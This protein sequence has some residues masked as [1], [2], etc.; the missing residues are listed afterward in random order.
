MKLN[1]VDDTDGFVLHE[2]ENAFSAEIDI[3]TENR[4]EL[5]RFPERTPLAMAY[6]PYQQWGEV[7]DSGD[8]LE[9]GTLFP[10]LIFP[11]EKGEKR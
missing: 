8:A 9:K 7:F 1:L 4:G 5:S 2:R 6:V 11:F 10:E 3:K